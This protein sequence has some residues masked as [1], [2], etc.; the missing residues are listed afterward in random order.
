MSVSGENMGAIARARDQHNRNCP[1]PASRVKLHPVE[2]ERCGWEEGDRIAGL[3]VEAD[4]SIG[5]GTFRV[6]CDGN[7]PPELDAEVVEAVG[8]EIDREVKV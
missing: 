4:S 3:T 2:I 8:R 1:F 6:V 7:E 5:T